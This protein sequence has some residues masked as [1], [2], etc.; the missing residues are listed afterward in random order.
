MGPVV[1]LVPK[2]SKIEFRT[3]KKG[4]TFIDYAL[5]TDGMWKRQE[6]FVIALGALAIPTGML[7]HGLLV[8]ATWASSYSLMNGMVD[9]GACNFGHLG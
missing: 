5:V 9:D 3:C 7:V 1:T 2:Q 6:A 8:Q 4:V